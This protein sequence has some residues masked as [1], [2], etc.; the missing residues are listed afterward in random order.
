MKKICNIGANSIIKAERGILYT[1]IHKDKNDRYLTAF[2]F[3]DFVTFSEALI[4]K[5]VFL[6]GKF[7]KNFEIIEPKVEDIVHSRTAFLP[8]GRVF[9]CERDGSA[10]IFD[11]AG[12]VKWKGLIKYKGFGPSDI[13]ADNQFIW[14]TFPESN[15]VIKYNTNSMRQDFVIGGSASGGLNEPSGVYF[16]GDRLVVGSLDGTIN[17]ISLANFQIEETH[18]INE[19]IMQITKTYSTQVVLCQSGIYTL[20]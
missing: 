17:Y 18:Q 15:A 14:C 8:N 19:A 4:T 11:N 6:L 1:A 16:D 10:M 7:G 13:T 12:E 2:K 9:V 20:D 3:Y 5:D